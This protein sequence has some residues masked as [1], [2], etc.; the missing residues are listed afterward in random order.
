MKSS[1]L[2][3]RI[4]LFTVVVVLITVAI[5]TAV[6]AINSQQAKEQLRTSIT[7]KQ[8][9]ISKMVVN[10]IVGDMEKSI[11]SFT[12][13]EKLLAGIK[14]G[15]RT[16]IAD[17][18]NTTSNLLE[19]T[20]VVSNIRILT[21]DNDL[22]FSRKKGESGLFDLKLATQT[23][24][25]MEL[26]RGVEKFGDAEPEIHFIFPIAPGGQVLA[27]VDMTLGYSDLIKKATS[28]SGNP[29]FV[30]D[31][32]GALIS[33]TNT[34]MEALILQSNLDVS[35]FAISELEHA[36]RAYYVVSQPVLDSFGDTIAYEVSLTDATELIASEQMSFNMGALFVVI[37]LLVAFFTIKWILGRSFK[38]LSSMQTAVANIRQSGDLS[39]RVEITNQDEI[40]RAATSI[41][42]LILMVENVLTESNQVM[43]AVAN[44][45]FKQRITKDY[46]GEFEV[47][48]ES[49]NGS[50]ESVAF[51]M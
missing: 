49:V 8:D 2:K 36:G 23:V 9:V 43:K 41:N 11:F 38:P 51:T 27:L 3:T 10:Q 26:T 32:K 24:K 21:K 7:D 34:E 13:E 17:R 33:S 30:F 31:L 44:G 42:E 50:V 20:G 1:S 12:R 45:D 35:Q 4:E 16:L 48:K 28:M 46:H 47:L 25:T 39:I 22:L 37:W 40:G 5:L 29:L 14:A 6:F 15:D 18:A 19:A